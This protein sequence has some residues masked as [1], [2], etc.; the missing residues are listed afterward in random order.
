MERRKINGRWR[1]VYSQEEAL[2]LYEKKQ[3]P[4]PRQVHP[5]FLPGV[6]MWDYSIVHLPD[7]I[8]QWVVHGRLCGAMTHMRS[9]DGEHNIWVQDGVLSYWLTSEQEDVAA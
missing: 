5:G 8:D 9:L 1:D 3:P 2:H 4:N 6:R 7:S